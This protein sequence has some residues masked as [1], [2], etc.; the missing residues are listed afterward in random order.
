MKIRLIMA[1]VFLLITNTIVAQEILNEY[2][3]TAANNNPSL[4]A[5]FN[6]YMASVEQ[7]SQVGGLPDL[8][9]AFGYFIMP[10]ETR[11]GPQNAKISFN[12]LFP[13][14]GTQNTR[15]DVAGNAAK[16]K[17]EVFEEAKSKLYFEVKSGY[18]ELYFIGKGIE[19]TKENISILNTFRNLALIKIE[20]GL[21]SGVDEIRV[22]M[23]LADLENNLALLNDSWFVNLVKF[24]NLLNVETRSQVEI[25]DVL[26]TDDLAFS[27]EAIFDSLKLNNHQLLNLSYMLESYRSQEEFAR[28]DAAPNILL[29]ADYIFVGDNGFSEQS[30]KD[31]LFVKAGIT[32]PL[33]RKKYAA[34]VN[35]AVFLQESTENKREGKINALGTLLEKVYSE[36]TDAGRRIRL[37]QKQTQLAAKAINILESEYVS[38]GKNFEEILRM[39][40]LLL[41]FSL[42]L[43]KA[44]GDKQASIAFII[45]LMGIEKP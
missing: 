13:W 4:K 5:K 9:L 34:M 12:Q 45:Y 20:A 22:E 41:K 36:Y 7:V 3:Q 43:E 44:R 27:H 21:A 11:N 6:E 32:I 26:W 23:D 14:F 28:K 19:I 40:K 18:F 2:L 30:G 29:G 15:E 1:G 42:E 39:E 35:E 37:Y 24:N 38:D 16:A 31:A 8:Q 25:P 10:V 33:Y 17:Y